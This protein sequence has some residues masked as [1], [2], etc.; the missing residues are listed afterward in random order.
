MLLR[1]VFGMCPV[2]VRFVKALSGAA[3]NE[4]PV[5]QRKGAVDV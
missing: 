2:Q 3:E 4:Q 1:V 5:D